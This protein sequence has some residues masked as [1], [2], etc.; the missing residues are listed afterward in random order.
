MKIG[1]ES[2]FFELF[3]VTWLTED[4]LKQVKHFDFFEIAVD[5]INDLIKA[6]IEISEVAHFY[7]LHWQK[8]NDHRAYAPDIYFAEETY[9][10]EDFLSMS[11]D[12]FEKSEE[13][14]KNEIEAY[15]EAKFDQS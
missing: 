5:F 2:A 15:L 6:N 4:G 11:K 8:I 12:Q 3:R 9:T 13:I 7:K 10:P 1:V 14:A